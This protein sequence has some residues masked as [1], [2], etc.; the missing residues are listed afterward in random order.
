MKAAVLHQIKNPIVIEDL[1][2]PQIGPADVL[3]QTR[4]CGICGTDI[5]IW[6]G[7]GY[8]PDLPF[9][10]GHE[11]S[12]VVARV[13]EKVSRFQVGDRVVPNIFFTCGH[14]FYCR[15]NRETQCENLDGILGVLKHWGG[16]GEY[17]RVPERQLFHLPPEIPFTEGAVIADAVV[18][19]VHAVERGRVAPGEKVVVIGVGGCG[20]AAAQICKSYG[21]HVIG[22]DVTDAKVDHA[23][24]LGIDEAVNATT[25]NLPEFVRELTDGKGAHCVID[26]VGNEETLTLGANSLRRGGRMV[27]LGYTQERYPLDPRQI[28]VHELEIIGTRSGGRQSTA[29]AIRLVA[30]PD[31]KPIVSDLFPIQDVN[32][33]LATMRAGEAL[34]RIVLTFGSEES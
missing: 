9:V 31:W 6:D 4:A 20:A 19:A 7:W 12:G 18:T 8:C 33:A 27:I 22:A 30:N 2:I 15:T 29:E 25:E 3:V 28:A 34:G 13:G 11:P 5:H 26:T 17:F 24:A 1:P 10:M 23:I 21:A 32:Q 14:C 16:Y